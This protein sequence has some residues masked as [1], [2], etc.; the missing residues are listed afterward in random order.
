MGYAVELSA[1]A[2]VTTTKAVAATFVVRNEFATA[3]MVL[4]NTGNGLTEF[5]MYAKY[6]S[7]DD[8][9]LVKNTWGGTDEFVKYQSSD[10][11]VLASGSTSELV[12]D[13]NRVWGLQF[14]AKASGSTTLGFK[15][16]AI[17]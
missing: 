15:G 11:S 5:E 3:T 9:H 1:S 7:D 12:L 8:W 2:T 6:R 16:V 17:S 4:T 10:P 14:Q 13:L